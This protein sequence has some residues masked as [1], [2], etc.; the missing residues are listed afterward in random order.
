MAN[1]SR[2]GLANSLRDLIRSSNAA[3][4]SAPG[5]GREGRPPTCEAAENE[6]KGKKKGLFPGGKRPFSMQIRS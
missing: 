3:P 5:M 6:G 4:K 1:G 2:S